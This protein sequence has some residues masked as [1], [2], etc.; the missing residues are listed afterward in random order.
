MASTTDVGRVIRSIQES[1]T[2]S[3][4][5]MDNA[6]EQVNTATE[7]ASLSGQ[8]L[9]EIVV[10]ADVTADQANAIA[11]ASEQQSAASEEINQTI[12]EVNEMSRQTAEGMAEAAKA[13][14]DLAVQAGKLA[15]LIS[16][17]RTG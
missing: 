14:S 15:S 2:K 3:L 17:M 6:V 1:T 7:S 4:V 11:T 10:T 16:E 12:I 8:A 5:S 13:V 9:S